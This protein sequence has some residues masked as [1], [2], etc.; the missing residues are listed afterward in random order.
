[1]NPDRLVYMAN[2]IAKG[3]RLKSEDRAVADTLDH[4]Q[5]FW[6]PRMRRE[7]LAVLAAGGDGLEPIARKAVEQI[8]VS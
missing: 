6:E 5:K 7:I 8:K 4:I 1:M 2:Q 3:F